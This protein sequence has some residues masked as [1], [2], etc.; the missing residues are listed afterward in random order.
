M[1]L[2]HSMT[3][4]E[5]L[6]NILRTS[7]EHAFSHDCVCSMNS[8]VEISF[9]K[10]QQLVGACMTRTIIDDRLFKLESILVVF[11]DPLYC[12]SCWRKRMRFT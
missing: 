7:N 5:N 9:S 1:R 2:G 8:S 6:E 12:M 4:E 10:I 3:S 11:G